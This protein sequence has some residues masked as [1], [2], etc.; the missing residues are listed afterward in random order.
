MTEI[1]DLL[2]F[3]DRC[4]LKVCNIRKL[5]SENKEIP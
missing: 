3:A 1:I 5:F 4:I 2:E